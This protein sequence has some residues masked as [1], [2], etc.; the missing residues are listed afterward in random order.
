M[1]FPYSLHEMVEA[2]TGSIENLGEAMVAETIV[3]DFKRYTRKN[4]LRIII[5]TREKKELKNKLREMKQLNDA[6]RR[7]K[8]E[9]NK[10]I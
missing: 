9:I 5:L 1:R 6:L 10:D 3:D 4:R 7:S 2:L 8:K